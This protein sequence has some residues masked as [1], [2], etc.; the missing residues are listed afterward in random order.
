[1]KDYKG[2]IIE[3]TSKDG[4]PYKCL[5]LELIPGYKKKV[6]LDEAEFILIAKEENDNTSQSAFNPFGN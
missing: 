4:K 3:A 2:E 6:F 1:M 5:H